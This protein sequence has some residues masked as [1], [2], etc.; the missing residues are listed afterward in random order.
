ML[1]PHQTAQAHELHQVIRET[2]AKHN[3][4]TEHLIGHCRRA[5]VVWAR[6]EIMWRARIELG[7]SYQLIARVLGGRDHTT[8]MYGVKRY[9]NWRSRGNLASRVS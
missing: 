4:S 6:F 8:I 9:E 3:V 5:G 1:T 7:M 2:A